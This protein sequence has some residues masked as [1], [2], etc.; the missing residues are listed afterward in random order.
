[1]AIA[2]GLIDVLIEWRQVS[3]FPGLE[4]WIFASPAKLG[5]QPLSY[6]FV[7]KTLGRVARDSGIGHIGSHSF[8][9]YAESETMPN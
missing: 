2:D 9:H 5:R 4:D 3:Q 8:R 6:T 1:M 7:W